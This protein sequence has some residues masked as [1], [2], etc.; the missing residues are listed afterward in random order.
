MR[1][2]LLHAVARVT[3]SVPLQAQRPRPLEASDTAARTHPRAPLA[4]VAERKIRVDRSFA[5]WWKENGIMLL[6]GLVAGV[7]GST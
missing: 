1:R 6:I 2:S 7:I 3:T 5:R 4:S